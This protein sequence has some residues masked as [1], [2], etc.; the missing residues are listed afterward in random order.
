MKGVGTFICC[1]IIHEKEK[2]AWG[3]AAFSL[4]IIGQHGYFCAVVDGRMSCMDRTC[5]SENYEK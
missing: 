3:V 5:D 2:M 1:A 4:A